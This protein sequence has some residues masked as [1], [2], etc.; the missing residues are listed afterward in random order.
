[1]EQSF[2]WN[3]ISSQ[4]FRTHI[5]GFS[6]TQVS[7]Y[8]YKVILFPCP[9]QFWYTF[10]NFIKVICQHHREKLIVICWKELGSQFKQQLFSLTSYLAESQEMGSWPTMTESQEWQGR[11]GEREVPLPGAAMTST[12]SSCLAGDSQPWLQTSLEGLRP[13]LLTIDCTCA[14]SDQICWFLKSFCCYVENLQMCKYHQLLQFLSVHWVDQTEHVCTPNFLGL[15]VCKLCIRS[16][17]NCKKTVLYQ[18]PSVMLFGFCWWSH[19]ILIVRCWW[20]GL[21]AT[22]LWCE[23]AGE[24]Q[25]LASLV[26]LGHLHFLSHCHWDFSQLYSSWVGSALGAGDKRTVLTRSFPFPYVLLWLL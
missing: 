12:W 13:G 14:N 15:P 17:P 24:P 4:P 21:T 5:S 19:F 1:M 18:S 3:P 16:I 26:K 23:G 2:S 8:I 7:I 25:L 11:V 6:P 22:L 9:S 10:Q 20:R